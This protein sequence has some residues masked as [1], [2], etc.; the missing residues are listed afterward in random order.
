MDE[1]ALDFATFETEM[2]SA[3][4]RLDDLFPEPSGAVDESAVS[5]DVAAYTEVDEASPEGQL[6][7]LMQEA[8]TGETGEEVSFGIGETV[9]GAMQKAQAEFDSFMERIN[10]DVL[11]FAHVESG[12][13]DSPVAATRINWT[14]DALTVLSAGATPGDLREHSQTLRR[15]LMGRNL[16]LRMFSTVTIAAGKISLALTTP[17]SAILA[18][19]MAYQYVSQLSKQWQAFQSLNQ[20]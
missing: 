12:A 19:P 9:S 7:A 11:N 15:E 10:R 3:L 8:E 14:G 6:L 5:F 13:A 17:G 16:R 2:E 4:T 1:S 20:P 18:L